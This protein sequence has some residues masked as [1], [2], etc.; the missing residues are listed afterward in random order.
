MLIGTMDQPPSRHEAEAF[1]ARWVAGLE[2]RLD[3]FGHEL[4][5]HGGPHLALS[6]DLLRPL[7]E[8]VV[9]HVGDEREIDLVPEWFGDPHRRYGWTGYGSALVEGLIAFVDQ[10]YQRHE[11]GVAW[12]VDNDS[13]S[14]HF[15]QPVP[16]G[17]ELPPAWTQVIGSVGSVQRGLHELDRLQTVVEYSLG[18][19]DQFDRRDVAGS[20]PPSGRVVVT[21][22]DLAEWNY[23][24]S[25]DEEVIAELE[26]AVYADLE[27]RLAS[28]SGV[29]SA[30]FE[31]REVCLLDAEPH[32]EQGILRAKV[33]EIL[34]EAGRAT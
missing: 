25:I 30:M 9:E 15:R 4:R 10:L 7:L 16:Q 11:G 20:E 31:D 3:W 19:L 1:L 14:A 5:A 6:T 29:R 8:F 24:V 18:F 12:V 23:Q 27:D 26:P 17:E 34:D 13:R 21:P 32:M 22:V 33:Q 28:I 2:P